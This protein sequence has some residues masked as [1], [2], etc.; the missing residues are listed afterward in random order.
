MQQIR[1]SMVHLVGKERKI[2]NKIDIL[3]GNSN[4]PWI[5]ELG[6]WDTETW[7]ILFS[8]LHAFFAPPLHLNLS[9]SWVNSKNLLLLAKFTDDLFH[10]DL[11]AQ[12][13][14]STIVID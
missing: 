8:P 4:Y 11:D 9:V 2:E 5:G 13:K 7:E 1:L 6:N 3:I 14:T 10:P 12:S